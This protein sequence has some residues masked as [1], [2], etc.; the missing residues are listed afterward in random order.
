MHQTSTASLH[1]SAR[2]EN[3]IALECMFCVILH[4][5]FSLQQ[6]VRNV[7]TERGRSDEMPIVDQCTSMSP[8]TQAF[9]GAETCHSQQGNNTAPLT[10]S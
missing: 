9:E 2:A 7:T 10:G 6:D 4:S 8:P 3:S 1:A 5:A